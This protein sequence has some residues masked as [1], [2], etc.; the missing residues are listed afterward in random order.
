MTNLSMRLQAAMAKDE[1]LWKQIQLLQATEEF[2]A[3][4]RRY[5]SLMD[6][7]NGNEDGTTLKLI[8]KVLKEDVGLPI[9]NIPSEFHTEELQNALV[10]LQEAIQ[11]RFEIHED[12]IILLEK[13]VDAFK[14]VIKK[15]NKQ[16]Y[17]KVKTIGR[18]IPGHQHQ[19][20]WNRT[21][22]NPKLR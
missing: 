14:K 21:R 19:P 4:L 20:A 2:E 11:Q 5:A 16:N 12:E 15:Q 13:Q 7:I 3:A 6:E 9:H 1:K 17:P 18:P 8:V 10:Q 22:S